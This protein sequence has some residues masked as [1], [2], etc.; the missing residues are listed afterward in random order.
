MMLPLFLAAHTLAAEPAPPEREIV[1]LL[2]RSCSMPAG[3]GRF[4]TYDAV[5]AGARAK[6]ESLLAP[7]KDDPSVEVS[8]YFFGDIQPDGVSWRPAVRP[9]I[10]H[11]GVT[12]AE[13][14]FDEFF[15]PDRDLDG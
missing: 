7:F 11:A 12:A 10:E 8:L 15:L 5:L 1:L 14:R 6:A 9:L 2:D 4:G 13:S 3:K